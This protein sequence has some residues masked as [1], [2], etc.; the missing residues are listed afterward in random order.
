MYLIELL[1]KTAAELAIKK[2]GRNPKQPT[3][4]VGQIQASEFM[5]VIMSLPVQDGTFTSLQDTSTG[6]ILYMMDGAYVDGFTI[7]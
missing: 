5:E 3:Q 7:G 2:M 6:E 4:F 1:R